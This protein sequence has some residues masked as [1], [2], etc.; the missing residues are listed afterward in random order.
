MYVVKQEVFRQEYASTL[1]CHKT[2]I[3]VANYAL[4]DMKLR[5]HVKMKNMRYERNSC[6]RVGRSDPGD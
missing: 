3:F 4:M 1:F 5:W 6:G 2:A